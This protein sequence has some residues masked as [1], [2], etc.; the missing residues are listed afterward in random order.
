[1]FYPGPDGQ[2]VHFSRRVG[3]MLFM[4]PEPPIGAVLL[5]T[6]GDFPAGDARRHFKMRREQRGW[7]IVGGGGTPPIAWEVVCK[8]WL[9]ASILAMPAPVGTADPEETDHGTG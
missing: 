2:P 5:C 8:L 1:V 4:P 6:D 3:D 9:P 7:R